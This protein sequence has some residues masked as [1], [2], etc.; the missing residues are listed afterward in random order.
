MAVG[1]RQ[2]KDAV[3]VGREEK[4]MEKKLEKD[5]R[6]RKNNNNNNNKESIFNNLNVEL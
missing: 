3:G 6:A 4:E 5:E 1:G 2:R